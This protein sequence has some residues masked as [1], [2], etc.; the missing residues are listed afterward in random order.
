[1]WDTSER[2]HASAKEKEKEIE[3]SVEGERCKFGHH[4]LNLN[5]RDVMDMW[6]DRVKFKVKLIVQTERKE[7]KRRNNN[8]CAKISPFTL[9]PFTCRC[10]W[11]GFMMK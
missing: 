8:K 6:G 4:Q 7:M 10:V 11:C 2:P 5:Q 9:N 1:M 3:F